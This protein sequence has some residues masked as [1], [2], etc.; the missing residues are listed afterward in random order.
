MALSQIN[1]GSEL[2]YLDLKF[3]RETDNTYIF[4]FNR[5]IKTSRKGNKRTPDLEFSAFEEQITLEPNERKLYP[6]TSLKFYLETTQNLRGD[7]NMKTQVFIGQIKPHKEVV[8]STIPGWLKL[9]LKKS[10]IDR[11]IFKA[12][13]FR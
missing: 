10:G 2:K 12:H 4:S 9:L 11:E 1:R 13:S 8:K 6:Y 3:M 5:H 7:D